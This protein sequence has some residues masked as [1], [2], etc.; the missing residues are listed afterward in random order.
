MS[1]RLARLVQ[2]LGVV[3]FVVWTAGLHATQVATPRYD[4]LGTSRFW[5]TLVLA[6]LLNV[7]AYALGLPEL[8]RGRKNALGAALAT[9]VLSATAISLVMLV[10]GQALLPRFVLGAASLLSVAWMV[11]CAGFVREGIGRAVARDRVVIVADAIEAAGVEDELAR[12]PERPASIIAVVGAQDAAATRDGRRPLVEAVDLSSATVLVLDRVAQLDSTIVEQAAYLHERGVRVRTLSLFC[13]EWLGKLPLSELERVSL[14]FDIG[15][16][17]RI[18]YGRFKRLVDV[19]LATMGSAVLITVVPFVLVGNAIANRGPL[20]FRQTR[21]GKGGKSFEILK[22]RSM[23]GAASGAGTWTGTDD[24]RITPFGNLLRRTHIDELPQVLN[25]LRG[26]LSIVGPRPEQPHYV[27]ELAGKIPFYQLR[28]VVRPGLT[29]WAQVKFPYGASETDALEKLQYEFF[30]LRHQKP[31][32]DLRI[33]ARTLR[34][35]FGRAG[36]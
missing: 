2:S 5:W 12:A 34:T 27:Q 18:R 17:H 29:G 14:M 24:C 26:N 21:I 33:V 1:L 3:A 7:F 32:F 23:S 8:V 30:Y 16:V 6:V 22:F 13:E 20:I 9:V 35:V 4:A 28:H 15:E 36:R 19:V 10:V 11:V 25:V 31:A